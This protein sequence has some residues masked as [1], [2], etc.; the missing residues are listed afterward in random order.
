MEGRGTKWLVGWTCLCICMG[1]STPLAAQNTTF[2]RS[3]GPARGITRVRTG[4]FTYRDLDLGKPV[5]STSLTIQA[6]TP[7]GNLSFVA[8]ADF[9]KDFDGFHSQRWQ[10]IVKPDFTP[11]I[12]TL[13]IFRGNEVVPVFELVYSAGKVTGSIVQRHNGTALGPKQSLFALLPAGIVDQRI[14][15]A[16]ILATDIASGSRFAFDVFDPGTGVSHVIAHVGS[17]EPLQVPAGR[18]RVFKIVYEM[19]KPNKNE[20]YVLYVSAQAP[21]FMIREDFPNGTISEL[22]RIGGPALR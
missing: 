12:A 16:A 5:G 11:V 13:S 3:T 19:Q 4:I 20:H 7:S 9:T 10:A 8:K 15:W 2:A 1:S 22:T 21:H 14:D 6:L 18:F 17:S